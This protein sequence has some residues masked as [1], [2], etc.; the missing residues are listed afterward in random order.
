[1]SVVWVGAC[2]VGACEVG[3]CVNVCVLRV[4][5]IRE[6]YLPPALHIGIVFGTILI[7]ILV[8]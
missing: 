3:L 7:F 1:M 6:R 8:L 2:G 5:R 4:P